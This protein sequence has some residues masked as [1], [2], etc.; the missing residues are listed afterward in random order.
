MVRF[1]RST[2]VSA[3]LAWGMVACGV[4]ADSPPAH[5]LRERGFRYV[6]AMSHSQDPAVH[7]EGLLLLLESFPDGPRVEGFGV[8]Q[9]PEHFRKIDD[10]LPDLL[11]V[12]RKLLLMG[13]PEAPTFA[14][15][16]QK[17]HDRFAASS[18][19][20]VEQFRRTKQ[21]YLELPPAQRELDDD[22]IYGTVAFDWNAN[23]D[24]V[25]PLRTM[26]AAARD[27]SPNGRFEAAF[28][29][30]E[31]A[32]EKRRLQSAYL[33]FASVHPELVPQWRWL[34]LRVTS[35]NLLDLCYATVIAR[36]QRAIEADAFAQSL[37]SRLRDMEAAGIAA[38]RF[39]YQVDPA[40]ARALLTDLQASVA[41]PSLAGFAG[42]AKLSELE[43][44]QLL[45]TRPISMDRQATPI[46]EMARSLRDES[47][48]PIWLD[49]SLSETNTTD[50][51]HQG[52]WLAGVAKFA[53]EHQLKFIR[54]SMDAY[55]L[56]P[57]SRE[58]AARDTMQASLG[59]FNKI[60]SEEKIVSTLREMSFIS[61]LDLPLGE[62]GA[63]LRDSHDT[64][65]VFADQVDT[66]QPVTFDAAYGPLHLQL[67]L[68][69]QEL[70]LEWE[71][72]QVQGQGQIRLQPK[73]P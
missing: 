37:R 7:V 73:A 8:E 29:Q 56:G 46:A 32:S 14:G 41:P 1:R 2:F 66:K 72:E 24:W 53:R 68:L 15:R 18:S 35:A 10:N 58:A 11:K 3:A 25:A 4:A 57:E 19:K 26:F 50:F 40:T 63:A 52:P 51:R 69:C 28:R 48:I 39:M 6:D 44:E 23:S 47:R 62:L 43:V 36:R 33:A 5:Q 12:Y 45:L 22:S 20:L 13:L 27:E 9:S 17:Q 49:A 16:L 65:F 55:W 38:H 60:A 67:T 21:Q 31:Q 61:C 70:G 54:L 42:Y 59:K 30:A 71:V 34:D 64:M